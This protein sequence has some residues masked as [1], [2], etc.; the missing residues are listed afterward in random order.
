MLVKMLVQLQ[1]ESQNT[2][3]WCL[4][5]H[6]STVLVLGHLPIFWH[7]Y[8]AAVTYMDLLPGFQIIDFAD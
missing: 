3:S 2:S 4:Y 5:V 7:K 8:N 6:T 1:T